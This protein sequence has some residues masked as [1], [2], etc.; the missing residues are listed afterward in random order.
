MFIRFEDVLSDDKKRLKVILRSIPAF[1]CMGLVHSNKNKFFTVI[2]DN[3][4]CGSSD[5]KKKTPND[6]LEKYSTV[7]NA[8][9]NTMAYQYLL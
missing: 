1:A 2:K 9:T 3:E 8:I 7:R 6:H 4:K 5:D